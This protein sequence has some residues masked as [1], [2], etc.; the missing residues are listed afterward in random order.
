MFSDYTM[1][2]PTTSTIEWNKQDKFFKAEAVGPGLRFKAHMR[3]T[4][5]DTLPSR[6]IGLSKA[7]R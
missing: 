6:A 5:V 7:H 4:V 2:L 3:R 1:G